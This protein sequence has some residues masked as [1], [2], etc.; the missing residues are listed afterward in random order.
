MR[1][2][3]DRDIIAALEPFM[4]GNTTRMARMTG[5]PR[6]T[7]R[8]WIKPNP[9]RRRSTPPQ[10]PSALIAGLP[11]PDYSYLLGIY[12]G[13]GTLSVSRRG[14]YRL[15][16]VMDIRYPGI[17]AV[18][19]AAM[20]AVMPRNRV[21]V[22]RRR[23]RAVEIGCSSKSWPILFPQHG[24]GPKHLRRIELVDWQREIVAH[25]PREFIRGLIHSDGCRSLNWV[26]GK[27]YPRY[28][29]TQVSDDIR[30]LFCETCDL[31]GVQWRLNRWNSVSIA[32]APSVAILDSFIGPKS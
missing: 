27:G 28:F 30:N 26:N 32:R 10:S 14:V 11:W 3:R 7:I 13:D 4:D 12:L 24:S 18:C 2:V 9:R 21:L 22:Q 17:I 25:H 8:D 15:R 16:V 23:Y 5:I 6:S 31:L 1:P 19:V 20:R 29:F